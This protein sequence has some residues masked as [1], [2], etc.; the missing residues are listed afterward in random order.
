M[1]TIKI[2]STLSVVFMMFLLFSRCTKETN[3]TM[4]FGATQTGFVADSIYKAST[5]GYM[6]V[7][8]SNNISQS[9]SISGYI[10]SDDNANPS[11]IVGMVGFYPGSATIPIQ[12]NNYW[13]V[14]S[15][16]D[17]DISITWIPVQE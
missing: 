5:D 8:Y 11:K 9:G 7:C 4:S 17:V 13:K 16:K 1:K 12:K 6:T 10:Y 2:T 15:V 3:S 14:A